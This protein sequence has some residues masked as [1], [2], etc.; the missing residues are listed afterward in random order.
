MNK[1]LTI[2]SVLTLTTLSGVAQNN[3]SS[4]DFLTQQSLQ[5]TNTIGAT[6]LNSSTIVTNTVGLIYTNAGSTRVIAAAA[7]YNNQ[8]RD[9]ELWSDRDGNIPRTYA[10]TFTNLLTATAGL[11]PISPIT[12][13]WKV[14]GGSGANAA[15][16]VIVVPVDQ[17]GNESTDN[18]FTFGVTPNGATAVVGST[19]LPAWQF[20]G[21]PKLRLKS[22][23]AGDTDATS[24]VIWH[25]IRLN[26]FKP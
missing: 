23:T 9:L 20:V 11:T 16:T 21:W 17:E 3:F 18:A 22:I 15:N 2:L 6:N 1:I 13:S 8:F 7:D 5:T 26:G 14:T 19:N 12:I 25:T 24:Q 4:Q 10:N